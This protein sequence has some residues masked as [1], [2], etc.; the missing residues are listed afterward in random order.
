MADINKAIKPVESITIAPL[1]ENGDGYKANSY[2]QFRISAADLS[3]WLTNDSYLRLELHVEEKANLGTDSGAEDGEEI[4]F[5]PSYIRNACNLFRDVQIKY[6]GDVIYQQPYNI[7]QNTLKMLSYGESY[8]NANYPTFT[9]TKMVIDNLAYL[10]VSNSG[11]M[12]GEHVYEREGTMLTDI[13]IPINQLLPVFQDVDANGFPIRSLKNYIEINLF[14][15]EPYRYLVDWD[16]DTKDFTTSKNCVNS[17]VETYKKDDADE[18]D[19]SYKSTS[20]IEERFPSNL[21]ALKNV[22]M[23]CASY[24]PDQSTA[25]II[26]SKC[27]SDEGFKLRY[28]IWQTSLRQVQQINSATNA[29]PFSVSTNNT[30]SLMLYCHRTGCSPSVMYRPNINS[31]YI[32][33]GPNQLPFQPIAGN[34]MET[35]FEYK[36]T[37]DDVLNNIDTYFT[38]TNNDYNRSYQ[39]EEGM[40]L[41]GN[42][43]KP[44]SSF[45]LM[46]ANY[47]SDPDDLGS[48]SSA[49]NN[50]YQATFNGLAAYTDRA[51]ANG[52]SGL[53][54]V[55]GIST[56]M[57]LKISNNAIKTF[58]L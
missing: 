46:G 6:G 23:Y 17:D 57:G 15:A 38:E 24:I 14:V 27:S 53:T 16:P 40:T 21:V 50:Q 19:G 22:R 30:K 9:T 10:K 47:V 12:T 11:E 35:P 56:D 45:V 39:F 51:E 13:I 4:K 52:K 26:D 31:L 36:F 34:T 18:E 7:E 44:S 58:N 41:G 54:F 29:I 37:S 43:L 42:G 8:L 20:P 5:T 33:F 1:N 49:W 25:N 2:I 48:P 28:N 32:K 3:M 55:L